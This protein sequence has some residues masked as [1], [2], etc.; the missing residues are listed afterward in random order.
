M[1]TTSVNAQQDQCE[2]ANRDHEDEEAARRQRS[3]WRL[4][5]KEVASPGTVDY[6][7]IIDDARDP[8]KVLPLPCY[9]F[10]AAPSTGSNLDSDQLKESSSSEFFE[11]ACQETAKE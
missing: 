11:K 7:T 6:R 8:Y 9:E 4:S 10:I 3:E 5:A 1:S 2:K